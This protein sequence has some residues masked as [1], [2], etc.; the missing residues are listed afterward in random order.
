MRIGYEAK[1]VFHNFRGLGNYSRTLIEGLLGDNFKEEGLELF[2]YTPTFNRSKLSDWCDFLESKKNVKIKYPQGLL[3]KS[4]PSLWRSA[5]QRSD[6]GR[7]KIDVYHG[8]SHELPRKVFHSGA[9]SVVTIHDLIYLRYPH[10][11]PWIDRQVYSYK[12]QKS[13]QEA[14]RII[15][16]CEQTKSDLI[17]FL[18]VSDKKVQVVYQA[19]HPRFY[20]QRDRQEI[21][22]L[23]DDLQIKRPYLLYVG[24]LE[25]RK[26][27]QTLVDAF[28]KG[29]YFKNYDLVIVGKGRRNYKQ[30]LVNTIVRAGQK[31]LAATHFLED[32]QSDQL[33]SLYQQAELF[34]FPSDFEGFGLPIVEALFS[35]T[36]VI[37]STGSCFPEAGGPRTIY[38]K[39]GD[40]DQLVDA[41]G[42]VL[43]DG[44]KA[45]QMAEIGY[46]FVQK[47]HLA[48]TSGEL[49][50]FYKGLI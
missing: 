13:C 17:D 5:L 6:V 29:A 33:P 37:T 11:F 24:A 38:T 47:F 22:Q 9:A 42:E 1:R 35:K 20:Q 26:N 46:K 45:Q 2:L 49:Y 18:Q 48:R 44:Q 30:N 23:L 15:A 41:I 28:V 43:S 50:Q 31:A 14:S 27:V 4:F 32:I 39:A 12:F 16:I 34:V 36:P 25:Q 7:D 10:Y 40:L 3:A 19:C 8:L 21:K